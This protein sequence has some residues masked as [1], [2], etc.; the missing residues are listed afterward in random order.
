MAQQCG[1]CHEQESKYKCKTCET[2]YCSIACYKSHKTTHEGE[3]EHTAPQ[4][5]PPA[6][7]TDNQKLNHSKTAQRKSPYADFE[8]DPDFKLL[9][10][11][12]PEL[13]YEL[14]AVFALTLEPGPDD[15]RTWRDSGLFSEP[16]EQRSS[17][18]GGRGGRSR[19]RGGRQHGEHDEKLRGPWTREKGDRQAQDVMHRLRHVDDE[20]VSEGMVEFIKLCG[21]KFG[22]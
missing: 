7:T 16:H 18:R 11:R 17:F 19:N 2:R 9:M 4:P 15:Q 20:E 13:Y 6:T 22:Q 10:Q 1:V 3:Q 8:H 5:A 21:I 14:S 12:Y